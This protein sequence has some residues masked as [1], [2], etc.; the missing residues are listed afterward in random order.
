[1]KNIV[2]LFL[3]SVALAAVPVSLIAAA[4]SNTAAKNVAK[5]DAQVS[6]Y[7][8]IVFS[9]PTPGREDEFNKWYSD[10]HVGDLLKV[11]GIVAG[12]RSRGAPIEYSSAGVR[13]HLP[14]AKVA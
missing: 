4:E 9:R 11:P 7:H 2:K 13:C 12:Q 8:L 14:T 3:A 6:D 5:E 1:M 10:Q